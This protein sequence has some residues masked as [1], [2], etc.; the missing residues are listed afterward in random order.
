MLIPEL[1]NQSQVHLNFQKV[2]FVDSSGMGLLIKIVNR[3]K[4]EKHQVNILNVKKE[5]LEVFELVQMPE[6][7]GKDVIIK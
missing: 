5:V 1:E 2:K 6:I 7:L 4:K 3:L